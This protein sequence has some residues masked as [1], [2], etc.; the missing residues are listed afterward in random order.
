MKA[1]SKIGSMISMDFAQP[2]DPLETGTWGLFVHFGEW[3]LRLG[4]SVICDWNSTRP[5]IVDAVAALPGRSVTKF[6]VDER[7]GRASCTFGDDLVL[8]IRE[9]GY[10][11]STSWWSTY[12]NEQK[13]LDVGPGPT[14]DVTAGTSP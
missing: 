3:D 6:D 7:T 11:E 10:D 8:R 9:C 5:Q 14:Y 13:V 12:R 1:Q 4:Q 2:S